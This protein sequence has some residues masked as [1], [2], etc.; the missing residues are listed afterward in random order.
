MLNLTML[1]FALLLCAWQAPPAEAIVQRAADRQKAQDEKGWTY[2]FKEEKENYRAEK[3]GELKLESTEAF[4]IVMLE[5][6]TYRKLVLV[7]GRPLDAKRQR[8]VQEEMERER[9]KR[10]QRSLRRIR[11][12]VNIGG[13]PQVLR[14][15]DVKVA[16]EETVRG[17]AAWKVEAEPKP[18]LK[19][20]NPDD[21]NAMNTRRVYWFDQE[22]GAELKAR[23]DYVRETNGFQPGTQIEMEF[24]PVGEA[25]LMDRLVFRFDLKAMAVVRARGEARHRYYDYQR[26]AAES[27][28]TTP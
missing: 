16:G 20:A 4:E 10:K 14:L 18:G 2:T 19:P 6:E 23:H 9:T 26:F 11:R 15:F 17:R 3:N 22:S 28:L 13:L 12:S 1:H 21:R 27:V 8:Q 24:A 7:D 5:G 25:W